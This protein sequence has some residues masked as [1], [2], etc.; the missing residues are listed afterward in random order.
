MNIAR[1][2]IAEHKRT[3]ERRLKHKAEE[4]DEPMFRARN[5]PFELADRAQA[6]CYGGIGLMH[7]LARE[8]GLIEAID[9]NVELLKFHGSL[10]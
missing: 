10:F 1:K 9:R 6:I 3:I 7:S 2:K 5:I 8:C 4:H